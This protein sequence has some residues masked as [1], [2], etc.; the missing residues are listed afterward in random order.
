MSGGVWQGK[1]FLHTTPQNKKGR[2]T[3]RVALKVTMDIGVQDVHDERRNKSDCQEDMPRSL[4]KSRNCRGSSRNLPVTTEVTGL[5]LHLPVKK[6]SRGRRSGK[7]AAR[8]HRIRGR[9]RKKISCARGTLT[10]GAC[11]NEI[12]VQRKNER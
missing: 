7:R 12:T 6:R 8:S 5:I 10:R 11:K 3:R 9:Q 1:M 4:A 2:T